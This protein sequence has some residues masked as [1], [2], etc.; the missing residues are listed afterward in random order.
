MQRLVNLVRRPRETLWFCRRYVT[1][2]TIEEK[3]FQKGPLDPAAVDLMQKLDSKIV[4]SS[5]VENNKKPLKFVQ[6]KVLTAICAHHKKRAK[7][8]EAMRKP[9][10]LATNYLSKAVTDVTPE[11]PEKAMVKAQ[12]SIPVKMDKLNNE[13]VHDASRTMILNESKLEIFRQMRRR[14]ADLEEKQP[15]PY[16]DKWMQDYETYDE[17]VADDL[18]ADSEYGT[19]GMWSAFRYSLRAANTIHKFQRVDFTLLL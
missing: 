5:Y 7:Y 4:Y 14:T 3:L 11:E 9:F 16:P 10:S 19:P 6:R 12:D 1:E 18:T 15:Q 17:S 13:H 2:P 8:E